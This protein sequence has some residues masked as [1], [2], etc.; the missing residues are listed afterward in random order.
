M[1]AV[2]I[3]NG[4][5]PVDALYIDDSVSEPELKNG[6]VLIRVKAFALNR[7]DLMQREGKYPVPAGTSSI[8]GVDYSGT[9]LKIPPGT[10]TP[11]QEGDDV[12]GLVK[13]GAYAELLAAPV[14]TIF[15]KPKELSH[16]VAASIPEV[17]FTATQVL[18]EVGEFKNGE[19]LLFHA[20]ASAVGIAA[21]QLAQLH[22]A[23]YVFATVGSDSKKEAVKKLQ[24]KN[25]PTKIIPIN[26]NSE[27]F[28]DVI[29]ENSPE[30]VDVIIDPVGGIYFTRNVS[31]LKLD[32]RD[33][34]MGSMTDTN[35]KFDLLAVMLK[36][37]QIKGTTLRSRPL[38]YQGKI[39][40]IVKAEILPKIVSGDLLHPIEKVFK[41][42]EIVEA[43]KLMESNKTTG[44][45]VVTIP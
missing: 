35:V 10:K 32:G 18:L 5:G 43:H 27:E 42:E 11:L 2:S 28:V 22:N 20:G 38:A 4:K 30:G 9:V 25:S 37:L 24:L 8:L 45:I 31:I 41:L 19:S 44:K 6:E 3:K 12:F 29:K 14:E 21:I 36:R 15:L 33:V 23:K 40:D 39:A 1:R 16:E 34:V 7:M 17:W 26:Y 13:G